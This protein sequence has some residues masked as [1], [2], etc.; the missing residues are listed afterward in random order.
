[1]NRDGCDTPDVRLTERDEPL[2]LLTDHARAALR[3]RGSVVLVTGDAGI[4]KTVLLRELVERTRAELGALWG[5]CDS[6]STPR[7]LGP[8]RDV[9]GTL[10]L[11]LAGAQ[12]EIFAAAVAA[13]RA[14]P[15]VFV[16]EDLHWA[17]EATLDLVRFLAR[18][19]AE[20]PLLLVVSYR[21]PLPAGHPLVGVL[22]DLVAAPGARRLPL[23]PLSQAAVGEILAGHGIDA[24]EVHRRTAGNPFYV[25]QIVAQP[26]SPLPGTVRDAV[27]ARVAGLAASAR[28]SLEL[29]SCT[30]EAVGRELLAALGV[31][32]TTVGVLCGT[33][34]VD[35]VGNGVV[36]R[37]EIAR[38]A[39][40]EAV[41]PGTEPALHT[42]MI[43]ALEAVGAEPSLLAHHAVA[44]GDSARILEYAP[45][46]GAQASRSGAHRESVAF[47]ETALAVA[48]DP[49]VRAG[50]LEAVSEELY[51]TDRLRAAIAAREQALELRR[52]L[53]DHAAVGAAHSA[54]S[55]FSWYA[56]DRAAT[57]AHDRAAIEVL[58]EAGLPAPLGFALA[59]HALLAAQIGDLAEA[60]RAAAEVERIADGLDDPAH[61]A[62]LLRGTAAIGVS[63]ARLAAGDT[64][65]RADLLAASEVGVR[66]RQDMLATMPMSNLCTLD[67]AQG[68]LADA[69]ASIAHALE[70]STARDTPICT[71]L[72]T[73]VRARLRFLQG[74]WDEAE[75]D[76]RTVLSASDLP[77][78]RVW[79]HLVLGLLL[80]RREAPPENPHLDEMWR[81]ATGLDVPGMLA[82]AAGSLAE[83]SWI[84]RT[85][86]PRLGSAPVA[87]LAEREYPGRE[88]V[89]EQL[90]RWRRRLADA[91]EPWPEPAPAGQPY[92]QA[93]AL[94]DSGG[95]EDLLE[96]LDLVDGLGARAVADRVRARLREAGVSRIP[97]GRTPTTL[98]NPAGLTARQTDVLGLLAAGLTNAEIAERLVISIRTADHHVSAILAKLG[99]HTRGD[100]VVAARELGL[101]SA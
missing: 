35:P 31:T 71:S 17:D 25:S 58:T 8:L 76:A 81:L 86:D 82:P 50:L 97:R 72:Q 92:E 5:M 66:Y 43:T 15:R 13:L 23:A 89:V 22:G 48:T 3:G 42:A 6:L 91:A 47:Y 21:D 54:I 40:L 39:I 68:R 64:E 56:A 93:L 70:L 98:A 11:S 26:D 53:G 41:P 32:P 10:G 74:R 29:L 45:A 75:Q 99:V 14:K 51:L 87:A 77:L 33:G 7:P 37:H 63:V 78:S 96:A 65:V 28:H 90:G 101:T 36:F 83:N 100:A 9:A 30:P 57:E 46:A 88:A 20:L 85:P 34:L 62:A 49:A 52:E 16:V 69:E 19:I 4:G 79:P 67:V 94:W 80:A 84:T 27:L 44:A 12:H 18:R 1:M 61:T 2:D 38:S 95:S 73:G 60:R 59:H 55:H 24:A